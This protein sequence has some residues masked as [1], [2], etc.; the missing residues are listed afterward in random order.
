MKA[1]NIGV[2]GIVAAR[3]AEPY[4]LLMLDGKRVAQLTMADARNIAR[5]IERMYSRTE[6]D[7]MIHRFFEGKD[8]PQGA[9]TALMQQFRY[10]RERLDAEPVEKSTHTPSGDDDAE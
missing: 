2:E 4:L 1:R 9:A 5:D 8:Y 10:L 6:A 3:N 7:A